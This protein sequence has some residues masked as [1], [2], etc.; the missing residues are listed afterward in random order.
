MEGVNARIVTPQMVGFTPDIVTADL[1]FI[2]LRMIYPV[3][4]AL[5]PEHGIAVTLI[6]PQFEAGRA[7]IGKN[8]VVHS[9]AVH[10]RVLEELE[11]AAVLQGL[12]PADACVSPIRGQEGN[13]EYL[14]CYTR[15][16]TG[17]KPDY[18]ALAKHGV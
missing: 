16:K 12:F 15:Q 9:H 10:L 8:G 13:I 1:S 7:D 6:K 14:V 17:V 4:A 5:L 3:I 18:A 2:S 11:Q